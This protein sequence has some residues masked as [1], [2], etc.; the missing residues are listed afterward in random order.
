MKLTD[1]LNDRQV[2]VLRW[3]SDGCPDAVM[4]GHAYKTTAKALHHRKLVVVSKKGG[5]WTAVI[6]E[7]GTYYLEHG[8]H[9][10]S[11]TATVPTPRPVVAKTQPLPVVAP[12]R[13]APVGPYQSKAAGLVAEVTAAGGELVIDRSDPRNIV[14]LVG[15][16]NRQNR[17]PAGMR[18]THDRSRAGEYVRLEELPEW[19]TTKL[20]EIEVPDTLR[21][22]HPVIEALRDRDSALSLRGAARTRALRLLNALVRAAEGRG[23]KVETNWH[24]DRNGFLS[25]RGQRTGLLT[26]D[27]RDFE[28]GVQVT[29]EFDRIPHVPTPAELQRAERDT[30][31]RMP[32]WDQVATDLLAITLDAPHQTRQSTWRDS[33]RTRLE[34]VLAEVLQE[35]ELRAAAEEA[36][37]QEAKRQAQLKRV[38]WEQAIA[39]ARADYQ[40]A[41]LNA[42]LQRQLADWQASRA[43][44][45]YVAAMTMHVAELSADAQPAAADWLAYARLRLEALDPLRHPIAVPVVPEPRAEELA[46]FLGGWSPYGPY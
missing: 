22:P 29:P 5:Q 32:K 42:A 46:P 39:K 17:V 21:R 31:F 41:T 3:I 1:P 2:E 18:L 4:E 45:E 10:A 20:P 36:R 14:V 37:Q 38:R 28:V 19:M 15:L 24:T 34:Q 12:P 40:R 16:A 35:I 43:L 44:A 27:V 30:W 6:T 9:R 11:A 25:R 13:R 8:Q 33:S 26:I 7:A 23:H